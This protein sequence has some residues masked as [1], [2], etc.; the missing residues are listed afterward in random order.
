[1]ISISHYKE[2]PVH[3][4]AYRPVTPAPGRPFLAKDGYKFTPQMSKE[5]SPHVATVRA[6]QDNYISPKPSEHLICQ[7]SF[8]VD[9]SNWVRVPML[10]L[11]LGWHLTEINIMAYNSLPAENHREPKST[12][13]HGVLC[14]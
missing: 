6:L 8:K 5:K 13:G 7:L 10:L 3:C 12:A 1:M 2:R 9:S 4:T 11:V 14:L